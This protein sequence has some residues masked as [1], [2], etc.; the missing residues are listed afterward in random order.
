[1][2]NTTQRTDAD[3]KKTPRIDVRGAY[4]SAPGANESGCYKSGV[5]RDFGIEMVGDGNSTGDGAGRVVEIV[6]GE[7]LPGITGVRVTGSDTNQPGKTATERFCDP[8]DGVLSD[9]WAAA[10]VTER[11]SR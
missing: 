8:F 10:F 2:A 5:R 1:M 9:G 3:R 11:R 6:T 4:P 7:A